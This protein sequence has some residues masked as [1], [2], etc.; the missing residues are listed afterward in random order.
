MTQMIQS[1]S[2]EAVRQALSAP[3]PYYDD[4]Q[5]AAVAAVLGSG[6]VNYWTGEECRLFEQEYATYLGR[7]HAI[8]VANGTVALELALEAFGIG[9]GDEVVV[10]ARTYIA[11]ASCAVM[12]GA[13]PVVADVDRDSQCLTA[14]TIEAVL[15]PATRA[16]VVVHLAGWPCDMDAIMALAAARNLIVIEDCAQAHGAYYKG[17]PVGSFGHAAA[18]S[19]CQDKIMTTGGE[20]GLLAIDDEQAWQRAWAFKDIGRSF[21]AVYHRE[22]AP[23][24][25]WLTESFGTNW[26]M[27]EMQAALGRIQLRRLPMWRNQRNENVI[28]L[29][30]S[31]GA[32]CGLRIPLPPPNIQHAWYKFYAFVDRTALK[33][34]WSRD[35]IMQEIEAA[36]V[37]C[38]V[39]S[40]GE[41]YR[42]KAFVERGWA[43]SAPLEIACEL[44]NTSLC[45]QVHPTLDVDGMRVMAAVV[46]TV[47]HRATL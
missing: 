27:T 19:F 10:P 37:S 23:G 3:W 9:A 25:R 7:A 31:L 2:V 22:H 40:C 42:E 20:G 44:G 26:R 11:S 47:M 30:Y 21:D 12:R 36:G 41:I 13:K 18:F 15:S 35:K 45:F 39:G 16:V 28:A 43:P 32:V 1:L 38:S 14:A 8:A 33:A 46:E 17:R 6:K 4:E 29:R 34:D 5:I 24:F